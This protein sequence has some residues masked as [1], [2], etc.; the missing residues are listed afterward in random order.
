[1]T[2]ADQLTHGAAEAQKLQPESPG[3]RPE[4]I[5][6]GCASRE[7]GNAGRCLP[8]TA[9]GASWR[10]G[11]LGLSCCVPE[12]PLGAAAAVLTM[13]RRPGR[14][15]GSTRCRASASRGT[16]PSLT[17]ESCSTALNEHLRPMRRRKRLRN[18]YAA[19]LGLVPEAISYACRLYLLGHASSLSLHFCA[20]H[21]VL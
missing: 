8:I 17:W 11:P 2:S 9:G 13:F 14:F 18:I 12:D 16:R 7:G 10:E 21:S 6:S 1:M 15:S 5:A 3:D 19:L 4:F 20:R